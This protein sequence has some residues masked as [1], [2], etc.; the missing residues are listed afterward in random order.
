MHYEPDPEMVRLAVWGYLERR[1]SSAD[2]PLI[3]S[4]DILSILAKRNVVNRGA[5][6]A[7]LISFGD[8]RLCSAARSIGD[9][10]SPAEAMDFSKAVTGPQFANPVYRATLEFCLIWLADLA[11]RE[12]YDVLAHI[13]SAVSSM[14]NSKS[15]RMIQDIQFNFGPYGFVSKQSLP[16]LSL[17]DMLSEFKPL[18][19]LLTRHNVPA[20][21]ELIRTLQIPG[22][23]KPENFIARRLVP[24]RRHTLERRFSQRRQR[25]VAPQIKRRVEERRS[26][27]RRMSLRR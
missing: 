1:R 20:L 17:D 3:A 8:R 25:N 5:A 7:G 27:T 19:E 6:F 14:V 2:E 24:T 18:L 12:K 9:S 22:Y 11:T 13:A 26:V 15:A 4:Q 21:T 23:K 16:Q 10:I